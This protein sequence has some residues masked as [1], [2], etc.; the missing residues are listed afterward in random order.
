MKYTLDL[1]SPEDCAYIQKQI[2]EQMEALQCIT[3]EPV[4]SLTRVINK[5]Y[6]EWLDGKFPLP[7]CEKPTPEE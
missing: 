6:P 7:G 5:R 3:K 2:D 4:S 1:A